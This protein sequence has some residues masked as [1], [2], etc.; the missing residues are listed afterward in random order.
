MM[1]LTMVVT[2]MK[3]M[4]GSDTDEVD[5]GSDNDKD[6]DGSDNYEIDDGSDNYEDDDGSDNDRVDDDGTDSDNDESLRCA[7]DFY[8]R[9]PTEIFCT[10]TTPPHPPPHCKTNMFKPFQAINKHLKKC[11]NIYAF[12]LENCLKALVL[13]SRKI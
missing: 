11:N 6:D 12:D 13:M 7:D 5:D 10:R 8:D 1:K 3:M 4:M 2:M 9:Q